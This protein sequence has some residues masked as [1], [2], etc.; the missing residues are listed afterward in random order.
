MLEDTD[1]SDCSLSDDGT[2]NNF[3]AICLQIF[4]IL[5]YEEVLVLKPWLAVGVTLLYWDV[6]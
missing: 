5:S 3:I 4:P 2:K 1:G 6:C